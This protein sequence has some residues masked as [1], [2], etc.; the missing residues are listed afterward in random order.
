MARVAAQR[1]MP[2]GGNLLQ[3]TTHAEQGGEKG[4]EAARA[5]CPARVGQTNAGN[6]T[7]ATA[8]R[9]RETGAGPHNIQGDADTQTTSDAGGNDHPGQQ[10]KDTHTNH[11]SGGD[12]TTIDGDGHGN[13]RTS[14]ETANDGNKKET[15]DRRGGGRMTITPTSNS[16]RGTWAVICPWHQPRCF[17]SYLLTYLLTR[18]FV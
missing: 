16:L 10:E 8:S 2:P 7:A 5:G 4:T 14:Q 17:H 15:T 11:H 6:D 13:G 3:S 9:G 18:L 12:W 1:P